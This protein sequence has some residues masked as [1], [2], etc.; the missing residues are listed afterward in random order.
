MR[1][2]ANGN[3]MIEQSGDKSF[4]PLTQSNGGGKIK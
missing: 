1:S 2:R 3:I 4:Y